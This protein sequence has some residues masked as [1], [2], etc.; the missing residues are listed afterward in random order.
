[1]SME[2]LPTP[3][4]SA[5][6]TLKG[7]I[8]IS[9]IGLVGGLLTLAMIPPSTGPQPFGPRTECRN[10][11]KRLALA[12]H[13]YH[14]AY[15]A[16]PPAYIADQEGKP[17]HSWR[18][19]LLPY[20]DHRDLYELYH[21]DEPWN[22]PNNQRLAARMPPEF[23]CPADTAARAAETSYFVVVGPKTIFP[24]TTTVPINDIPD[25]T[26]YTILLVE[27]VNSGINWLEP[28]DLTYDE[29]RRG[30]NPQTGWGISSYHEG[31]A[32]VAFADGSEDLLPDKTPI[33]Q[34]RLL[35]E[36]NDGR[37]AYMHRPPVAA[38]AK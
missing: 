19:L 24:G 30:I 18:V 9:A 27:A 38:T 21:F 28:R 4:R 11:L 22:G 36:R 29:A 16:F 2:T 31:G 23:G 1:M 37:P 33:Q 32:M 7:G 13:N 35:L 3:T 26:T 12:M 6:P 17:I 10:H 5:G 15:G 34:L 8:L 14:D 20:L 25:G